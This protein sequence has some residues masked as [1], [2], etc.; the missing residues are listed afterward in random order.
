[1]HPAFPLDDVQLNKPL[2]MFR[3][4][5]TDPKTAKCASTQAQQED[6]PQGEAIEY[7]RGQSPIFHL[8]VEILQHIFRLAALPHLWI[9]APLVLSFVNSHFRTIVLDTPSLWTAVDNTLPLPILQLYI[10]RSRNEPLDVLTKADSTWS[11]EDILGPLNVESTRIKHMAVVGSHP[12]FL[13]D[14]ARQID[15][16]DEGFMFTSL[17]KLALRVIN[18]TRD[19]T[20]CPTWVNFPSLRELWIQGCWCRGWVGP[21][22][23]FPPTLQRLRLSKVSPVCLV[24]LINALDGVLGLVDLVMEDFALDP[25]E[26]SVPETRSRVTLDFLEE[27]G[28]VNFS[29]ADINIISRYV[30]T[31]NLSTLSITSSGPSDGIADFLLPFS[32]HHPHLSSLCILGFNLEL[33]GL[34][35][36]LHNLINLTHLRIC[37]FGLTD[38]DLALLKEGTLFPRLTVVIS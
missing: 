34:K 16:D 33:G 9:R 27:L 28:F 25:D 10:A 1:M 14:W 29:I 3:Y 11:K 21:G 18:G 30:S 5:L 17:T 6:T 8:P 15:R 2:A 12:D 26:L 32:D 4:K 35:H 19:R 20:F 31:P 22:D 23:P 38:D 13:S 24:V 37:A 36:A 7:A